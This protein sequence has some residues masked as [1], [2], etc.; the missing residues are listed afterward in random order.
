MHFR[1][2]QKTGRVSQAKE[3]MGETY[4]QYL[5]IKCAFLV[6]EDSC[7]FAFLNNPR[8]EICSEE[9]IRALAIIRNFTK[10]NYLSCSLFE[11]SDDRRGDA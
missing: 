7:F 11:Q 4:I 8:H 1:D 5:Y 9:T 10:K 3:A 6:R 2:A